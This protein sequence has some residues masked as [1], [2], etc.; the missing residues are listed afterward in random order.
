MEIMKLIGFGF[1]LWAFI[2]VVYDQGKAA[3]MSEACRLI[4]MDKRYLI[5]SVYL[6]PGL[7]S[8]HTFAYFCSVV[9]LSIYAL[10][11]MLKIFG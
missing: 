1:G 5:D 9:M 8:V 6:E 10:N 7:R 4:D 2:R 3:G 11:G